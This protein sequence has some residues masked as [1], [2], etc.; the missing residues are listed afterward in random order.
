LLI[1]Y[2]TGELADGDVFTLCS[3]S[4]FMLRDL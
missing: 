4:V 1:F 2:L 3:S